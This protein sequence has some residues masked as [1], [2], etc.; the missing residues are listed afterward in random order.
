MCTCKYFW[1]QVWLS[2]G[3]T[4]D[5]FAGLKYTG[6]VRR[7][8]ASRPPGMVPLSSAESPTVP[9][10]GGASRAAVRSVGLAAQGTDAPPPRPPASP[11]RGS[12]AHA[13]LE[14]ALLTALANVRWLQ[15]TC[16]LP[17]SYYTMGSLAAMIS[18]LEQ[19]AAAQDPA[20]AAMCRSIGP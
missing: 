13:S 10:Y 20:V 9:P 3:P 5:I 14:S 12:T 6:S 1:L 15:Q 17:D 11:E 16:T 8:L 4:H 18:L 19:A 7:L 2:F